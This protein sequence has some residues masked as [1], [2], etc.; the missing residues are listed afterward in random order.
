[1]VKSYE[2]IIQETVLDKET[3]E[4]HSKDFIEIVSFKPTKK[5]GW[6]AMYKTMYDEVMMSLHSR[7]EMRVFIHIRDSF[8]IKK[9]E[10]HFNKTTIAKEFSSTRPTISRIFTKLEKLEA[11]KHLKD[12]VYRLNPYMYIPYQANGL[13]LQKEWDAL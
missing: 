7:L 1:M 5:Q 11:I 12:G 3:G 13:E 4:L 10:V 9:Q 8:T 6:C 2:N